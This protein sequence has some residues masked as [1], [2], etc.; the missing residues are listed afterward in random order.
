MD[1][2]FDLESLGFSLMLKFGKKLTLESKRLL[3][4]QALYIYFLF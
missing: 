3:T 1:E 4:C 2:D